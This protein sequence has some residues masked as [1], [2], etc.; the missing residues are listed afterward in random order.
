MISTKTGGSDVLSFLINI[1]KDFV[2]YIPYFMVDFFLFPLLFILFLAQVL[3]Y[4]VH[5]FAKK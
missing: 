3:G 5:C 1:I 2:H 4:V